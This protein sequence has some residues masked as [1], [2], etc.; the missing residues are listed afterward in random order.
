MFDGLTLTKGHGAGNDFVVVPDHLGE[1]DI[2]PETVAQICDR[3]TGIGGDGLIRVIRTEAL[4]HEDS[5]VAALICA[6]SRPEWFMDYR[7]ADGSIA[8]MCGNGVRVFVHYLRC[9]GL[10]DLEPGGSVAVATRGGTKKVTFDAPDY[11]VDMGEYQLPYG[12]GG[13]DTRVAIPGVGE[14]VALSVAMPNPHTVVLLENDDELAAADFH[15]TPSYD[16]V[17]EFGT[18]LELVVDRPDARAS[19]GTSPSER[20]EMRVLERGVGETLACGTGTCAVALA[21]LFGR[22]ESEGV[23]PI[24]SPGGNLSVRIE[25]GRAYLTGPAELVADLT[26]R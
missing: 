3:H 10:V 24:H 11:T 19:G 5:S 18:N 2:S 23:V 14:R 4:L 7:N 9:Q 15:A 13:A 21:V 12:P 1:L 26:L 20:V 6:E 25:A 17:P 16:P 22:G 8:E